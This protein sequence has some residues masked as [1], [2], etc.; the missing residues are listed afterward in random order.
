MVA[1]KIHLLFITID[2]WYDIEV[3][4][5]F[6]VCNSFITVKE[7]CKKFEQGLTGNFGFSTYATFFPSRLL[8]VLIYLFSDFCYDSAY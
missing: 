2:Q 3:D 7:L 1:L 6:S 8:L 5:F 4:S